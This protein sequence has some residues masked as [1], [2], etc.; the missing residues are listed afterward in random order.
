MEQNKGKLYSPGQLA[1]LEKAALPYLDDIYAY[2]HCD[3][4]YDHGNYLSS[5]CFIH[6][7]DKSNAL[8]LYHKADYKTHYKCRTYGCH[9]IFGNS[10]IH[11]VRGGLSSREYNWTKKGDKEA[12]FFEAVDFLVDLTGQA[13][14]ELNADNPI[15][16]KNKFKNLV[17]QLS[18]EDNKADI[19]CTRDFFEQSMPNRS[20][21]YIN[22]KPGFKPE[23][24]DKFSV[25]Y[26]NSQG[27]PMFGRSVVPILDENCDNVVGVTGRSVFGECDVCKG[28]HDPSLNCKEKPVWFPKWRH[29]KGFN[30]EKYLYNYCYAKEHIMRQNIAII[31]ESPGNVWRLD[32]IGVFNVVAIFGTSLNKDQKK[33]L[34]ES[35]A[36]ALIL[37]MDNDSA[38]EEAA[39]KIKKQC[40]SLYQIFTP[41]VLVENDIADTPNDKLSEILFPILAKIRD[42]L[43]YNG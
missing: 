15:F 39:N 38:G 4:K 12:T 22:R 7:G 37:L 29:N 34:D 25:R 6:E 5:N 24:L 10:L 16:E 9:E 21:Y 40:G 42:K 19:L 3:Q 27:K 1:L 26:C 36:L 14:G 31:V 23:T 28:Y 8:N 11:M 17:T 30:K 18:T 32:E 43:G 33:L 20:E 2:F 35:G 13:I 41:N